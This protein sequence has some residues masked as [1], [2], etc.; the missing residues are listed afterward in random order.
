MYPLAKSTKLFFT[1]TYGRWLLFI[2]AST[3][4]WIN[5]T[6][7]VVWK[8]PSKMES[9]IKLHK[10]AEIN[11]HIT[12][13]STAKDTILMG[14]FNYPSNHTGLW[15][16]IWNETKAFAGVAIAIPN[17][18]LIETPKDIHFMTY[19]QDNGFVSPY[20]NLGT[21]LQKNPNVRRLLYVHDDLL[22]T[23]SI[24]QKIG[25]VKWIISDEHRYKGSRKDAGQVIRLYDNGTFFLNCTRMNKAGQ[26][27]QIFNNGSFILHGNAN[28]ISLLRW[29]LCRRPFQKMY[30]NP[31][32]DPYR[33]RHY[34]TKHPYTSIDFKFGQ[35]DMLYL[36]LQSTEER[37]ALIELINLFAKHKLFLDCA[38]PTMVS[39]MQERFKIK[40]Y[41]APLCT[42][43]E[44]GRIR[45]NPS[46]LIQE[47]LSRDANFE[48]FHPIKIGKVGNWS[49]YFDYVLSL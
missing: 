18:T 7:F 46:K 25:G 37:D 4:I 41:N 22:I 19:Q 48:L 24:L 3:L 44:Y 30:T 43:W 23:G 10:N 42:S 21:L 39:M 9:K 31:I 26:I 17:Q 45:N 6:S 12:N 11:Y 29:Q 27:I 1:S 16:R 13:R 35:S 38:I 20:F 40:V 8:Y 5:R 15:S 14:Q 47:C 32:L 34:D 33:H 28:R 36:A 49:E 2:L